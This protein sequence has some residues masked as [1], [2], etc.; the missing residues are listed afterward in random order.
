MTPRDR[1]LIQYLQKHHFSADNIAQNMKIPVEV[2]CE[3][4]GYPKDEEGRVAAQKNY[5]FY[6]FGIDHKMEY[7]GLFLQEGDFEKYQPVCYMDHSS[8]EFLNLQQEASHIPKT[9]DYRKEARRYWILMR[10]EHYQDTE[11]GVCRNKFLDNANMCDNINIRRR[12][13]CPTPYQNI[14]QGI[15]KKL[16]DEAKL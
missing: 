8:T 15:I 1:I 6:E 10:F 5:N 16:C 2:V 3:I 9:N 11:W 4:V 13:D 14:D 7:Y 12:G